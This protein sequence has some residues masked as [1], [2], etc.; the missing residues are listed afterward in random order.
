MSSNLV[1]TQFRSVVSMTLILPS[2]HLNSVVHDLMT[3]SDEKQ[4]LQLA[5]RP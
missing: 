2:Q 5:I 1:L 4:D 3:M